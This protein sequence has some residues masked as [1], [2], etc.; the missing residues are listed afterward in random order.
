MTDRVYITIGGDMY[1][2]KE[3]YSK[4]HKATEGYNNQGRDN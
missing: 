1:I 2:L 3:G 4:I